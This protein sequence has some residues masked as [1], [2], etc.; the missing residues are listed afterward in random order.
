MAE[1]PEFVDL[2]SD[3][4]QQRRRNVSRIVDLAPAPG[5]K[6]TSRLG[7][8]SNRFEQWREENLTPWKIKP[9]KTKQW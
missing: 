8:W 9:W 7:H 3:A 6:E 4:T 1:K 2:I 5:V